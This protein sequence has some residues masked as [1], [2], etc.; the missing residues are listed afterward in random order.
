MDNAQELRR[1]KGLGYKIVYIDE[2][3]YTKAQY[4]KLEWSS[5]RNNY[6]FDMKYLDEPC[7][8]LLMGI[9]EEEGVEHWQIFETSVNN[10]KFG[11]YLEGLRAANKN[12]KIAVFMDN[13]SVHQSKDSQ[14]A[15]KKLKIEHVFNVAYSPEFN[16]IELVFSML[17]RHFYSKRSAAMIKGQRPDLPSLIT[18]G[19][20][21]LEKGKIQNCVRHALKLM[22]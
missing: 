7:L 4:K 13:L 19:I 3:T 2:T 8:C 9:S 21:T 10:A 16:P 5:R 12:Q 20:E 6:E 1:L 11:E 22:N 17:K 14:A 18:R 15:L